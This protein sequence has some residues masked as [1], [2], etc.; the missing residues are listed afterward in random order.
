VQQRNVL[1]PLT[2]RSYGPI[3]PNA[4][5][6]PRPVYCM[7]LWYYH[8]VKQDGTGTDW[9][10]RRDYEESNSLHRGF[11]RSSHTRNFGA[12]TSVGGKR[13]CMLLYVVPIT[14]PTGSRECYRFSVCLALYSLGVDIDETAFQKPR[15]G[16]DWNEEHHVGPKGAV[17]R[18]EPPVRLSSYWMGGFKSVG[19]YECPSSRTEKHRFGLKGTTC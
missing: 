7:C 2:W 17:I 1:T 12:S 8:R 4:E 3:W 10:I 9:P 16:L 11:V 15:I 19:S 6:G 5:M 13:A 18:P 14:S